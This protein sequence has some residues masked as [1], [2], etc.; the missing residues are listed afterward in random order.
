M[1]LAR[2]LRIPTA[3]LYCDN[4]EMAQMILRVPSR[5]QS[6]TKTCNG[7]LARA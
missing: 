6:R 7:G 2:V 3:I 5:T 1:R 4:D